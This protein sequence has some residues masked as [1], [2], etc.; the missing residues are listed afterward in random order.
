LD[1]QKKQVE[2]T[3]LLQQYENNRISILSKGP[4]VKDDTKAQAVLAKMR[5]QS[6]P[7]IYSTSK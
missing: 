3:N 2:G 1:I 5:L 4:D 6:R 7:K